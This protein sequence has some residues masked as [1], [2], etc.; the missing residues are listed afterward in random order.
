MAFKMKGHPLKRK[1][2]PNKFIGMGFGRRLRES[3]LGRAASNIA[4]SGM[5]GAGG[6]VANQLFGGGGGNQGAEA[7]GVPA[8]SHNEEGETIPMVKQ[9]APTKKKDEHNIHARRTEGSKFRQKLR[10][11]FGKNRPRKY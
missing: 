8:H 2:S 7:T 6:M 9:G 10:K 3:R 5:L 4:G 1:G 11:K